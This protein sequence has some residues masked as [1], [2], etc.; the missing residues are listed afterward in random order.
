M[1]IAKPAEKRLLIRL[2]VNIA[3]KNFVGNIN[4]HSYISVKKVKISSRFMKTALSTGKGHIYHTSAIIAKNSFVEIIITH[5]I[6]IAK[7][8]KTITIV[9]TSQELQ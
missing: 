5:L 8:L 9:P 3:I 6:T 7:K 1:K 2:F 4:I